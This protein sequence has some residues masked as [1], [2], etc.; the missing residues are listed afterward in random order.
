MFGCKVTQRFESASFPSLLEEVRSDYDDDAYSSEMR[1]LSRGAELSTFFYLRAEIT[2]ITKEEGKSVP[3][4]SNKKW[5]KVI[6]FTVDKMA[7][8]K[9]VNIKLQGNSKLLSDMNAL[10]QNDVFF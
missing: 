7:Y 1:W 2:I 10:L 9:E 4:L 8:F 5:I 6:A 3:Q